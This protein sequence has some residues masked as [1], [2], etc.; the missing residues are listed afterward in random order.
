MIADSKVK[1]TVIRF[2]RGRGFGFIKPEDGGKEVFVHWEDLVTDDHWPYVE[3]ETEVQFLLVE[4]DGKRAAKEVT[5]ANGEDIPV[6]TKPYEDRE[7]NEEVF[8]GAVKFFDGWKGF[9]FIK[10][11]EEI[12][13]DDAKSGEG[14]Y[15][16]R[17]A[18]IA[19]NAGKGMML[20]I[21]NDQRVSFKVYKDKKGLGACEV[22]NEDETPI[23]GEPRKERKAGGRKRKRRGGDGNRKAK[24]KMKTKE[25]LIEEREIDEEENTYIGT[26]QYYKPDKEF[27]F[28]TISEEITYKDVSAK[29]KIF[30]MKEDIVCQSD[31][32]GL[33]ADSEVMFKIYKDSKGLGACE[34]MNVDGTPIIYEAEDEQA[35]AEVV[36]EPVKPKKKAA[37]KGKKK[38]VVKRKRKT[39]N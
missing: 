39:K 23:E 6:F 19:T 2:L 24:K 13:W 31:E 15:F 7:V 5:L 16:K 26:V 34:V 9:G 37:A 14:L 32:I 28:I 36:K 30:V 1:G 4:E 18:L 35:E 25:E 38:K 17:E 21:N 27:G 8:K 3:R 20:K 33:K 29:E 22:Q 12:T 10:P 11:D